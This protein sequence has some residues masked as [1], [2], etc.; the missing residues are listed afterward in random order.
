MNEENRNL[1]TGITGNYF[2]R[3]ALLDSTSGDNCAENSLLPVVIIKS[4]NIVL[5]MSQGKSL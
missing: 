5:L 1:Q 2:T 4:A 3:F